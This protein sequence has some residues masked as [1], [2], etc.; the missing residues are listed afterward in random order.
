MT[1]WSITPIF[2]F[3]AIAQ[4]PVTESPGPAGNFTA[5]NQPES[6]TASVEDAARR[7]S[8]LLDRLEAPSEGDRD[9]S[10][11]DEIAGLLGTIGDGS[12]SHP[13]LLYL[14]A[15]Y[16]AAAG[17]RAEALDQLREFVATREG[18]T[19]WRAYRLLGDLFVGEY[20]RLAKSNYEQALALNPNESGVQY[21]LSICAL[22]LGDV[23]DGIRLARAAVGGSESRPLAYYSH[24]ATLLGRSGQ[25]PEAIREA[26]H[27][28]QVARR[29]QSEHPTALMP[30]LS[31]D[32]QY[33]LLISIL[34]ARISQPGYNG[35]EGD[36]KLAQSI[37]ERAELSKPIA[38]HQALRAIEAAV[39]REGARATPSLRQ[40][41][42]ELLAQ[43]GRTEEAVE[44]FTTLLETDPNHGGARQALERLQRESASNS[45]LPP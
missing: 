14:T 23:E 31:V 29:R 26:E 3:A 16:N 34:Q 24:L 21:G 38:A 27:A 17:R 42:G 11:F 4:T 8:E 25:W 5:G 15:R 7:V 45:G 36:L 20:P 43:V 18:R 19:E 32:V 40:E 2:F 30:L 44:V 1:A 13:R 39:I 41:Q 6:T 10:L 37:R 35:G 33:Q 28:L 9:P 12:P 22:K